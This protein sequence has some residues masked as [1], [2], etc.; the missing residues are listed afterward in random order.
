MKRRY[1]RAQYSYFRKPING[2]FDEKCD[3]ALLSPL[4]AP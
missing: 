4:L 1:E 3:P 2:G